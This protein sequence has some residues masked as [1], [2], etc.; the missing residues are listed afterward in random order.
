MS[1]TQRYLIRLIAPPAAVTIPLAFLFVAQVIGLSTSAA[2][3]V[4]LLLLWMYIVTALAYGYFLTPHTR[5]IEE[6]LAA[7]RDA[8]QEL[9]DCLRATVRVAIVVLGLSGILFAALC[10]WLVMQS[11]TG[12][13][14]FF[15]AA[16]IAAFPG[17]AWAYAAGKRF[18]AAL[19]RGRYV[20]P[21]LS[22]GKK[23]AIVFIGS[24]IVSSAALVE[25]TASKVL[26]ALE[27]LAI[28][29]SS[30]R[31]QRIYDTANLSARIDPKILD[32]LRLYIPSDYALHLISRNGQ[33]TNAGEP[34]TPE[35]VDAIRRLGT[36]DSTAFSSPHVVKFARLKDGS[37]LALSI[38]W[39]PYR[40]I[41]MQ[42]TLYTFIIAL[43]TSIIFSLGAYFLA[44]DV[45][46][47]LRKLRTTAAEMAQGNFD[48]ALRVFSDDEVG[49]LAE[50]FGEMRTNLRRLL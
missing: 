37:I 33:V 17:I 43:L 1:F 47:P 36:G 20:G 45:T 19:G 24:F 23:I 5:R 26:I 32:D 28:A 15:V 21:E 42:I 18:L 12:F 46:A 11:A 29:S 3:D 34:L 49:E 44:R 35:E 27:R 8:S 9:S 41:P 22:I 38:P 7:E 50:S 39:E 14:Y 6:A 31:F 10:T 40:K 48:I 30:E 25:L 16:L 13:G 4:A 2:I